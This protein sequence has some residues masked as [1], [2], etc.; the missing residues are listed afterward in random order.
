MSLSKGVTEEINPAD[1]RSDRCSDN[2]PPESGSIRAHNENVT[3]N[4]VAPD[5]KASDASKVFEMGKEFVMGAAGRPPSWFGAGGK[6]YQTEADQFGQ[7]PIMDLE[8]TQAYH[9]YILEIIIQFVIDQ[10]VIAKRLTTAAAEA[11]FTVNM[12]EISPKDLTKLVNGIPQLTTALTMAE[13][14]KWI[15]KETATNIFAFVSSNLGYEIDAQKEIDAAKAA[16]PD[17]EIDYDKLIEE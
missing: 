14:N 2:P 13:N 6:A 1:S 9:K 7:V 11:S 10:A 8:Q 16:P 5:L 3:W 15:T 12:P 4:A 17:N